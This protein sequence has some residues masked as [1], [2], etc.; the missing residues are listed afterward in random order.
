MEQTIR[1]W[2]PTYCH[3]STFLPS[4]QETEALFSRPPFHF[5]D[6]VARALAFL[7]SDTVAKMGFEY[8]PSSALPCK[9]KCSDESLFG[10]DLAMYAFTGLYPFDK[11]QI[12][13]LFNEAAMTAATHHSPINIDFGGSHVGYIPGPDGGQFGHIVRP[14]RQEATST[15]CGYL[16]GVMEPFKAVYDD[17][18]KNIL[19]HRPEGQG[20][21]IS[22]PNEFLRPS[23]SSDGIKLLVDIE[24]LCADIVPYDGNKPHTD[25]VAGRSVFNVSDE[26]LSG[27]DPETIERFSSPRRRSIG[28]DLTDGFFHIFDSRAEM[29][30]GVLKNRFLPYMKHIL[31]SRYAPYPL[32][33]AV[34]STNIEHN[35]LTD[36]VRTEQFRRCSFASFSGVFVDM[37]DPESGNYVNL[38]QPIGISIKAPG[39]MREYEISSAE[40]HEQFA[41]VKPVKPKLP[42]EQLM[43]AQNPD[44][45]LEQFTFRSPLLR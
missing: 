32:K 40:V 45:L 38:F 3:P 4:V 39:H 27:L 8:D 41:L 10:V 30:D 23:W 5:A 36:C 14:L 7:Q 26:F 37:F 28:A 1:N 18:C 33:A 25:M 16:M 43:G 29:V 35:K 9:W 19:L 11:G 22:I 12:G 24:R 13:G 34:T 20:V 2:L 6:F 15:D 17:A 44:R 21:K 31:A 42:L